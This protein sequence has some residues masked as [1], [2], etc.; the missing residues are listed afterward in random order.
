MRE[1]WESE[2][3]IKVLDGWSFQVNAV[4]TFLSKNN[5]VA[6][7]VL[8]GVSLQAPVRFFNTLNHPQVPCLF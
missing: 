3:G 1:E 7:L 8:L 2:T 6:T 5:P 4:L